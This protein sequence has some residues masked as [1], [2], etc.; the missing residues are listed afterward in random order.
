MSD[1]GNLRRLVAAAALGTALLAGHAQ[2]NDKAHF[3]DVLKPDGHQR[4]KSEEMVDAQGCGAVGPTIRTTLPVFEK[5]M[6]GKGWVLDSYQPDTTTRPVSGTLESYTDIR[7]DGTDHPRSD[8]TLQADTRLCQARAGEKGFKQ[9]MAGHGWKF[10]YAQQAPVQ[11]HVAPQHGL[12][13]GS[14]EPAPSD[15]SSPPSDPTPTGPDTAGMNTPIN[16]TWSG[17]N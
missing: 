10:L 2:A 5:C 16:P 13:S 4:G 12:G 11:Q 8:A 7:G 14:D 1:F 3:T 9:C 17:F 6:R 15:D